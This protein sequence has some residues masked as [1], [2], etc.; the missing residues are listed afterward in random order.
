MKNDIKWTLIGGIG[1]ILLL[2]GASAMDSECLAAPIIMILVG[3]ALC[4]LSA[5]VM[6]G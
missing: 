3:L 6:E 1:M 5:R 4:A 2:A